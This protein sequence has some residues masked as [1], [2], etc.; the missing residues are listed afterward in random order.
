MVEMNIYF[1]G[2]ETYPEFKSATIEECYE[3]LK[4][5]T[6][7]SIDIETTRKYGG[8]YTGEGL[9]PHLTNIVMLQI[10]DKKRQYVIDYRYTDISPLLPL[11]LDPK[12]T[13]L[14]HN[15]KFEYK[16]LFHNTGVRLENLYDTM[17]VEQ[18][19]FNGLNKKASLE[20]LNLKYLG[21]QVNKATRLEFL[22]I[23]DR[24][25]TIDQ[26]TYGAQDVIHPLLIREKQLVDIERKQIHNCVNLEMLFIPVLGDIEYKGM[27]FN[28]IQ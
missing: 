17:I 6:L 16:H 14:G 20:A 19:L 4:D 24:P 26:I 5:E 18:I 10:G 12:I 8:K 25:F 11:L 28:K 2:K 1:I 23:G 27:H 13:F 21:I 9:E 22:T 3:Y 15:V 7:I